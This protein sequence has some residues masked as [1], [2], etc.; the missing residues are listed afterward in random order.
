MQFGP[1]NFQKQR[2]NRVS[3]GFRV[4]GLGLSNHARW[5]VQWRESAE[6]NAKALV[7]RVFHGL[8]GPGESSADSGDGDITG[9]TSHALP[10]QN[11]S[12]RA[13]G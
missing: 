6:A 13:P 12:T 2:A 3:S 9:T 4:A 10:R 7:R 8:R 1:R 11:Q 5:P